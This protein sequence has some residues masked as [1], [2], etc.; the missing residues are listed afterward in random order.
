MF[1]VFSLILFC[2]A[3]LFQ[4]GFVFNLFRMDLVTAADSP[5]VLR[6]VLFPMLNV[7]AAVA[8]GA[9]M[10]RVWHGLD[11]TLA[12]FLLMLVASAMAFI[13]SMLHYHQIKDGAQLAWKPG[14]QGIG[15]GSGDITALPA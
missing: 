15:G 13:A 8:I 9:G 7:A 12:G 1:P 14:R 4:V 11:M 6:N 10:W 3:A 5:P 2:F